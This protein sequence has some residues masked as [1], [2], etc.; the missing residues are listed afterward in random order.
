MSKF[1]AVVISVLGLG[2]TVLNTLS[3]ERKAAMLEETDAIVGGLKQDLETRELSYRLAVQEYNFSTLH[4]ATAYDIDKNEKVLAAGVA[5]GTTMMREKPS[6]GAGKRLSMR[7]RARQRRAAFKRRGG[8]K[9]GVPPAG[10]KGLTRRPIF[11]R[12]AD[13]GRTPPPPGP[14]SAPRTPPKSRPK[15]LG[16][17][18]QAFKEARTAGRKPVRPS[19][20]DE[21][22][23]QLLTIR[24]F[25]IENL[26]RWR[27]YMHEAATGE[28]MSGEEVDRWEGLLGAALVKGSEPAM[29]DYVAKC[30]GFVREWEENYQA[31]KAEL[32]EESDTKAVLEK[33]IDRGKSIYMGL[34]L[35]GLVL[36]TVKDLFGKPKP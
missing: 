14:R 23:R 35:V 16:R 33:K 31:G 19:L 34:M 24:G 36:V 13:M 5:P 26:S 27:Q 18:I 25:Q 2:G 29:K 22:R 9:P 15:I 21:Q 20:S 32:E 8:A 4:A 7:E 10:V 3:V 6:A 30:A 1:L 11:A 28:P 17:G 12:M